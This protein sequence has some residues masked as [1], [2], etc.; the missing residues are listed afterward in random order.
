MKK[1]VLSI[2][3]LVVALTMLT[4]C[5][6]AK[7]LNKQSPEAMKEKLGRE[8]VASDDY[9]CVTVLNTYWGMSID[10]CLT[11]LNLAKEDVKITKLALN[12]TFFQSEAIIFDEKAKLTF[13]FELSNDY[14]PYDLGL[15]KVTVEFEKSLDLN[16]VKK[17]VKKQYDA[18]DTKFVQKKG[19]DYTQK[20]QPLISFKNA[21]K[22]SNLK[23]PLKSDYKN[24]LIA[25]STPDSNDIDESMN[26]IALSSIYIFYDKGEQ[27]KKVD[28]KGAGAAQVNYF[29]DSKNDNK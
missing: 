26:V 6:F 22:I 14:I 18:M 7:G 10:E 23:D 24:F 5:S 2:I 1:I 15:V 27:V 21:N 19:E 16:F 8:L 9:G 29:A 3:S 17:Q 11:A 28:F 12:N 25:T 4:G 20:N 13:N